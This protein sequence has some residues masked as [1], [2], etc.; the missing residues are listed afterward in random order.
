M[1]KWTVAL[2][3]G[4]LAV[5]LT[6]CGGTSSSG[7]QPAPKNNDQTAAN[8]EQ[9]ASNYPDKPINIIVPGGAGGGLD[10]TAR[11]LSKTLSET[12][13]VKQTINIENKPGGGQTTG[14]SHFI[15]NDKDNSYKLLL[16]STPIVINYL[17]KEATSPY[18][19]ADMKP[20]AQL[21][22]DYGAIVVSADSKY[23]DL[24]SLF[25][26]MKKNPQSIT[27]AGGSGPGSMD[28]LVVMLPAIKAGIDP[29]TIKYTSYDA[30]GAAMVALLG[31]HAQALTTGLS[32]AKAYLEAGKVKVL[33]VSAPNRLGGI[34]KDIPTYKEAGYDAEFINWRGLFGV[35][36]MSPDAVAFWEEKI[37]A[38]TETEEWKNELELNGWE[39][40]YKNSEDF[41]KFLE[42]QDKVI[43]EV[44]TVLGMAK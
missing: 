26:D 41:T 21:T 11:V 2:L 39:D 43:K 8:G 14:L 35:K 15:T 4:I 5:S 6:A 44:L 30:G 9:P 20:L 12:A 19:Y 29:K 18:S 16:P 23:N 17:R 33:A 24:P 25:E 40:G 32:E 36:D 10:T 3:T 37:K 7:T 13:I 34:F 28:H 27:F 38:L 22:T 42:E 31:G 1:K